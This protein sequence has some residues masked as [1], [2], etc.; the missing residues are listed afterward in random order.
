MTAIFTVQIV[1]GCGAVFPPAPVAGTAKAVRVDA[2]AVGWEV[3]RHTTGR[4][5]CPPCRIAA[6]NSAAGP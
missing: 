4:D 3:Q 5:V 6:I 1:C 2:A